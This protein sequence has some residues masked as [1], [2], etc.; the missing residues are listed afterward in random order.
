MRRWIEKLFG[1]G[2]PRRRYE[3]I[4]HL[5]RTRGYRRYLEIGVSK[6]RTMARVRC[7]EKVGVDPA[8]RCEA[9]AWTLHVV[10]SDEFFAAN[11]E[12]FD[13]VF[14]DGL[15]HAEQVLRDLLHALAVL[16]ANGLILL[17][18]CSPASEAA[19]RRERG[20]ESSADWNGDG[21]KAIALVR[22]S[23]PGLYC[24][25]IDTDQ[26]IGVVVPRNRAAVPVVTA[27]IEQRAAA[28]FAALDWADLERDRAA[29]L[30]LLADVPALEADLEREGLCP[31]V[32]G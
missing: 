32:R 28:R 2:A 27:E 21:W 4:N 24:R 7:A 16:S 26:G 13:L 3:I 20:A 12:R 6:G 19:Q 22:E 18:D 17:H 11:C 14:I 8:P 31:P 10:P 23:E 9:G 29:V 5:V 15:H 25:V 30:G 1:T